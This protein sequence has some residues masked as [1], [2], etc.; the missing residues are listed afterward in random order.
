MHREFITIKVDGGEERL[1]PRAFFKVM[2]SMLSLIDE[3]AK[4]SGDDTPTAWSI[5]SMQREN[6]GFMTFSGDIPRRILV[7]AIVGLQTINDRAQMPDGFNTRALGHAK[8]VVAELGHGISQITVK[9]G[10]AVASPTQHVSANADEVIGSKFYTETTSL[11]GQ[12]TMISIAGKKGHL[13]LGLREEIYGYEVV[14]DC[15]EE[16]LE[17]AK[18]LFGRRVS[19]EGELRYR[20]RDDAP[21]RLLVS[22][23][24]PLDSRSVGFTD[25][26]RIDIT[27]GLSSEDFIR[28]MRDGE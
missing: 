21:V 9:S 10:D 18:E 2:V 4:E 25:F 24:T 14:C 23:I 20:R 3:V 5:D 19:V 17:R 22:R 16:M 13:A 8:S 11:D 1:P 15:T 28:R 26:P 7:L 27:N 6:P 12:L